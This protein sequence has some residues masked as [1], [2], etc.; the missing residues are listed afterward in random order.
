M[1]NDTEPVAA[2]IG[3]ESKSKL[4]RAAEEC[5]RTLSAYLGGVLE[6]HIDRNPNGLIALE[7]ELTHESSEA[8]HTE[9]EEVP[10]TF[11]E[12]MLEDME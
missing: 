5:D 12:E 1:N 9:Q 7:P 6:G 11:V 3:A 4:E 10:D 2:R 8:S